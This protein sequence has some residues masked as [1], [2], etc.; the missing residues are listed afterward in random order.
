MHIDASS[1]STEDLPE[2]TTSTHIDLPDFVLSIIPTTM[3]SAFTEGEILPVMLVSVLFGIGVKAVGEPAQ[4]LLR[5]VENL[6]Q[7]VFKVVGW[8]M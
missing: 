6:S 1:L 5:G 3:F 8:V 4:G 7:V 2:G